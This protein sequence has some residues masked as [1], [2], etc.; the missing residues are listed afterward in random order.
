MGRITR[1]W[2]N[3][4]QSWEA[5]TRIA[6]V[7]AL[8]LLA[9]CFVLLLIGPENLHQPVL[10]G[11]IGLVFGTQIIFM[12]GNRHMVTPYTQAQRFYLAEDFV[13]A[14]K[15]LE[16]L[17]ENGKADVNALTLLAN[18]YRQ[19][20][21]LDESERV[22][23][24]ALDIRPFDPFPL[25]GFGRT[26][27]VKGIYAEAIEVIKRAIEAGAPPVVRFDLGD[28]LFRQGSAEEAITYLSDTADHEDE[29]FRALMRE[30]MLYRLGVGEKPG[31]ERIEAGLP[32]WQETAQRFAL[33]PY[34]QLLADDIGELQA[35]LEES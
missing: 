24:K 13:S 16:T 4:F 30:Y 5:S 9:L 32:Y 35:L 17:Q 6:F 29:S 15:I 11:F 33:T 27:L 14:R 2:L 12:W 19:L 25:Y 26:L 7:I 22:V 21:L 23:K 8:A 18:T 10:I 34:G 28:A 31:R 20:G 1:Y 3:V